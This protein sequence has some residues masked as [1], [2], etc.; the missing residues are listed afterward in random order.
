MASLPIIKPF[1]IVKDL[2]P[3]FLACVIVPTMNEFHFP[4][5]KEPFRHRIIP[6]NSLAAHTALNPRG[7]Q[8]GLK[9][10]TGLL[11]ALIGLVAKALPRTTILHG[12][13]ERI[14]D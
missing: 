13:R 14:Q 7:V 2:D 8:S 6:T 9:G 1:D 3:S 10:L 5:V 4:R 12:H 11:H